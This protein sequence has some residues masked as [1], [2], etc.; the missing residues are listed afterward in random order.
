LFLEEGLRL[1]NSVTSIYSFFQEVLNMPTTVPTITTPRLTLRGFTEADIDQLHDILS[2]EGVLR[3][4]P[5]PG[6]PKREKVEA[7]ITHQ[8]NNWEEHGYGLWAVTMRGED[9]LIGWNGLQYLPET[10]EIEIGF[11]LAMSYWGRGLAT[12]GGRAGV[13]FGFEYIK[14]KT[15]VAIVHPE[16]TASQN[17]IHKLGLS[18]PVRREYFGMDCYRYSMDVEDYTRIYSSETDL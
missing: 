17:V 6:P 2:V 13:R 7:I 5:N 9:D 11:V 8:I 18:H 15:L 16:N 12:E 14:L 1:R 4:F 10:D 3:Y